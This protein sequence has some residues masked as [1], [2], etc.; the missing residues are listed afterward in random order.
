MREGAGKKN[1]HKMLPHRFYC[2]FFFYLQLKKVLNKSLR[3]FSLQET[4]TDFISPKLYLESF[5]TDRDQNVS[6]TTANIC[7]L[8]Q[9]VALLTHFLIPQNKC[10]TPNLN[11]PLRRNTS[12]VIKKMLVE[13]IHQMCSEGAKAEKWRWVGERCE[14]EQEHLDS[15]RQ[16]VLVF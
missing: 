10:F 13:I 6:V 14:E 16:V 3:F 8:C 11:T 4:A 15:S 12:F 1:S 2:C 5:T 9:D 7:V